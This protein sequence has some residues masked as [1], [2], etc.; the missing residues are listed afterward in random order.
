[1]TRIAHWFGAR[2]HRATVANLLLLSVILAIANSPALYALVGGIA[3]SLAGAG[4]ALRAIC[5][6]RA[7]WRELNA[8]QVALIWIPGLLPI[9]LAAS[10]LVLVSA[11]RGLDLAYGL[12]AVLFAAQ[13]AMLAVASA[14]LGAVG[15]ARA[16]E[17]N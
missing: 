3:L 13:I 4:F 9:A 11:A 2:P 12:G 6:T 7:S 15:H 1:M 14:D 16:G 8:Y 17:A 5:W 10:G